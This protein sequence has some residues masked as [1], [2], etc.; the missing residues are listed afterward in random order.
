MHFNKDI[1]INDRLI[2]ESS[3]TYIIAEAGVNHNGDIELARRLIDE[4]VAARADAVK[5]QSFKTESL[6]LESV[7]KAAYQQVTTGAEDSQFQM[8]KKLEMS[9]GQM[10]ELQGY[11]NEKGITFLTTP[12]DEA[13]LDELDALD[14]PA[15]K[16]SST[17]LTNIAFVEKV[18]AK[19]KPVILST[20]MS[21]ISEIQEI[22]EQVHLINQDIIILQCTGN[23]PTKPENINLN[24]LDTYKN[25]FDMLVG[26]SDHSQGVGASP[27]AVALGARVIEKHFTLD[28]DMEG[29]DHVAS[30]D[31]S[32][33]R[34]LV[35]TVRRVEA[36]LG[37]REKRPTASE[38]E[39]REKLQK[40]LV[41]A[42]N[43]AKG[44]SFTE[45]NIVGM[46]TGGIG[47]SAM[48]YK[49]IIGLIAERDFQKNDI[50]VTN[51]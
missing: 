26:F 23:Y 38:K 15:Y 20:A 29:P 46:R 9:V 16:V 1:K 3:P 25:T 10:V 21:Y 44:D 31:P 7:E 24:I 22:L 48:K 27:F 47:I 49:A 51:E 28:K 2:S 18:A 13:S 39:T 4:A 42:K 33:L 34:E 30:L 12:F 14:L 32:E 43:I 36:Y 8:L 6:I 35:S 11:C 45:D 17:D 37:Q 41:A 50:I 19:G 40:C 5:F